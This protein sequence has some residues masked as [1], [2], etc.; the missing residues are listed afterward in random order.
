MSGVDFKLT[1]VEWKKKQ[2]RR[3]RPEKFVEKQV[4]HSQTS[5]VKEEKGMITRDELGSWLWG[6]AD[7]L[8]GAVSAD[9]YGDFVLPL[10]FY[11]RLSDNYSFEYEQRLEKYGDDR[12]ARDAM[13][14]RAV[15]PEGGLWEDIRKTATNVGSKLNDVLNSIAKA[16]PRLDRVINRTDFNN[17]NAIPEERLVRLIEHL[18]QKNLANGNVSPDILGDEYEYLLKKFNEVA[19]TRA[20]APRGRCRPTGPSPL[21]R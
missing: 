8:R 2:S 16:N 17:P 7:I 20:R 21:R 10:L 1:P 11:K 15:V 3:K 4:K 12:V 14:Y 19:P 18:S 13:F 9:D 5:L 6:A